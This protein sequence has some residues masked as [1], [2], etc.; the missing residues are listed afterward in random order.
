M[1]AAVSAARQDP[2]A[3]P[4]FMAALGDALAKRRRMDISEQLGMARVDIE[5]ELR[6]LI[7][8]RCEP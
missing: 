3:A 8:P 6:G 2:D 4:T 5:I 7:I 1:D